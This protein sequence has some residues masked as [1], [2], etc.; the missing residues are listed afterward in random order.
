MGNSVRFLKTRVDK[1]DIYMI[2]H[3]C[4]LCPFLMIDK[5]NYRAVCGN[6]KKSKDENDTIKEDIMFSEL[7][8]RYIIHDVC[9]IPSFCYLSKNLKEEFDNSELKLKKGENIYVLNSPRT[10]DERILSEVYVCLKENGEF[11]YSDKFQ[12]YLFAKTKFNDRITN[13]KQ[14]SGKEKNDDIKVVEIN[15]EKSVIVNHTQLNNY[16]VNQICSCCG[17]RKE[18][19]NRMTNNGMCYECYEKVKTDNK[20][21]FNSIINNFRI[22]RNKDF[23]IKNYKKVF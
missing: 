5:E 19:V 18:D 12:K 3:K 13:K 14:L 4:N 7:N 6:P 10:G 21:L 22:K 16:M 1:D 20:L 8:N 15:K 17:E 2:M 9:D 23:T 11:T